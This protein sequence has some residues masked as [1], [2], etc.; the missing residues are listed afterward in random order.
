[1]T[2]HKFYKIYGQNILEHQ[3]QQISSVSQKTPLRKR[4]KPLSS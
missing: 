1:M 3:R 4:K 2:T